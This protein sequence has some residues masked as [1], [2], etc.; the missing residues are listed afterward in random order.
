MTQAMDWILAICVMGGI[1]FLLRA[2][3]LI[4]H[5]N[6]LRSRLAERLNRH[7]P[8]CVMTV[9]LLVSLKGS[10]SEPLRLASELLALVV[11]GL[12]YLRW[13]N[14]LLS[15]VVGVAA[16]GIIGQLLHQSV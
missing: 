2:L 3:P 14:P 9:L 11:V 8:L 4:A 7:M 12:S 16:L 15:V 10:P 5:R 1:T 6:L 13:R